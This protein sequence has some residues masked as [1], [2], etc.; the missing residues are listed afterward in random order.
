MLQRI[1][2]AVGTT[3]RLAIAGIAKDKI[4]STTTIT[5]VD[6]RPIETGLGSA[7]GYLRRMADALMRSREQAAWQWIAPHLSVMNDEG[8][9]AFGFSAADIQ[10]IRAGEPVANILARNPG[11]R[12]I[13]PGDHNHR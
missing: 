8:L 7:K 12:L 6:S 5:N 1:S 4:M 3:R 13:G 2:V 11:L 10:S 9:A